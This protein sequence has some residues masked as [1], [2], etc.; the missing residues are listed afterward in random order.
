MAYT[1][2]DLKGICIAEAACSNILTLLMHEYRSILELPLLYN[3]I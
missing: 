1:L 3:R 2:V